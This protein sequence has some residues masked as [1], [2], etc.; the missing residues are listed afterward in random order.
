MRFIS[1]FPLLIFVLAAFN[2]VFYSGSI[3]LEDEVLRAVMTS[4]A[5]LI[6]TVADLLVIF[7]LGVLFVEILKATGASNATILDHILSTG[8]FILALVEFL[9]VPQAGNAP[10]LILVLICFMD[11]VAGYAVSIRSARRD[12]S[13]R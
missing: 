8:V 13:V 3:A 6:I 1:A 7:A 5:L 10:F 11:V 9:L 12:V 4:G 2:I